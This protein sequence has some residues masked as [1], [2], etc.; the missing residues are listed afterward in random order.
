MR[1]ALAIDSNEIID[2]F[3]RRFDYTIVGV[4][5]TSQELTQIKNPESKPDVLVATD[6]I[7]GITI[8]RLINLKA[9]D[10]QLRIVY[11]LNTP[12]NSTGTIRKMQK[13]VQNQIYDFAIIDGDYTLGELINKICDLIDNP[14]DYSDVKDILEEEAGEVYNN[15]TM[16]SSLKPGTGKTFVAT[17]LAMAI[18]EYGQ[19]K[20]RDGKMERPRVLLVDGDLI[21]LSV[22]IITRTNNF[23]RNMLTALKTI[24]TKVD[25]D[26]GSYN[27]SASELEEL[28]KSIRGCLS[29]YKNKKNLYIMAAPDISID[30]LAEISPV[31]FYF[32]MK[33]L[34]GAFDV[35]IAD[36][37]S[38]FDHQTTAALM[39]MS[40]RIILLMDNDYNNIQN[41]LRYIDKL[42]DLG[43]D[44]KIHFVINKDITRNAE[45]A[46]LEDLAYDTQNI[47]NLMIEHRIPLGDAGII[48][49]IDFSEQILVSTDQE[50]DVRDALLEVANDIWKID[51]TRVGIKEEPTPKKKENKVLSF[52]NK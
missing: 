1:I 20:R 6:T 40:G 10:P 35:V 29:R 47:G 30:D 48:K 38:A 37:N 32:L 42:N 14:R 46:C 9:S 5:K 45:R 26:D 22:G 39:E 51:Y 4:Y 44:D 52:L 43:Y 25:P 18:A 36:S 27:L 17:N 31:H 11:L 21:N 50:D 34:V 24:A 49:S 13:L 12:D 16:V 33:M 2:A 8:Q 7:S 3:R 15:V 23:D 28:K 41:N 19:D